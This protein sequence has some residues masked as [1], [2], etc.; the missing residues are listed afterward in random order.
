MRTKE[1]ILA[2]AILTAALQTGGAQWTNKTDLDINTPYPNEVTIAV[3]GSKHPYWTTPGTVWVEMPL[4]ETSYE[5]LLKLYGSEGTNSK[6]LWAKRMR[7][8]PPLQGDTHISFQAD[9]QATNFVLPKG[10]L[11]LTADVYK[12]WNGPVTSGWESFWQVLQT[13]NIPTSQTPDVAVQKV[14][15]S[16]LEIGTSSYDIFQSKLIYGSVVSEAIITPRAGAT[17]AQRSKL[18]SNGR[19]LVDN[20]AKSAAA[21]MNLFSPAFPAPGGQWKAIIWAPTPGIKSIASTYS[22]PVAANQTTAFL[23]TVKKYAKSTT[24]QYPEGVITLK[25]TTLQG[26]L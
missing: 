25:V 4:K 17:A 19:V 22:T 24:Y 14:A 6:P 10:D 23:D 9:L 18:N 21:A 11:V 7:V 20:V 5:V 8:V 3:T 15:F 13:N 1:I 26:T 2:I 12:T 16:T